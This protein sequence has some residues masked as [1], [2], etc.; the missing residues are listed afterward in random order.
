MDRGYKLGV[1]MF[2]DLT[3]EEFRARH[4]GYKRHSGPKLISTSFRYGN[5]STVPATKDWRKEGA[6]TPVKD[7]GSCGK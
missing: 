1:N 6:V 4:H 2:A 5:V 7:Q 3:K